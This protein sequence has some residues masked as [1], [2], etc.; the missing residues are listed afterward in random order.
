[1]NRA[2]HPCST[3][4]SRLEQLD[5]CEEC[6]WPKASH[7]PQFSAGPS[8]E[9]LHK[10]IE[11]RN[12]R[13]WRYYRFEWPQAQTLLDKQ[14]DLIQSL[15]TEIKLYRQDLHP[16]LSKDVIMKFYQ[17]DCTT[18]GG[19]LGLSLNMDECNLSWYFRASSPE[20]VRDYAAKCPGIK[21]VVR[22]LE[23]PSDHQMITYENGRYVTTL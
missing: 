12:A 20:I 16:I 18:I 21:A 4:Q 9:L 22:V 6:C 1:M 2:P 7:P 11:D 5:V 10:A 15:Q 8:D 14:H 23:I 17:V 13:P 19:E 3:F